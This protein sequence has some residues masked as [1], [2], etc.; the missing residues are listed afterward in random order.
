MEDVLG[1]YHRP[2]DEKHP[3]VC[4]DESSKQLIGEVTQ[5]IGMTTH[6]P[7]LQDD[8]YVRNG[9]AEI[10][11]AVEP[12]SGQRHVEITPTRTRIDWAQFVKTMLNQRYPDADKVVLVMDNLNT[13]SIGSL[14]EAFSPEEAERLAKRLEIHFTPKHGSWLNIA[15]I[16][17]AA[18][19]SGCLERRIENMETMKKEV[20]AWESYRNNKVCKVNWRFDVTDARVKLKRLYPI[21]EKT[22]DSN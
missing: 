15:E 17:L 5:P 2:Y 3:V 20:A 10:L 4:F 1:V 22:Q 21:F 16:E 7:R 19:K 9:V 8:E 13:H 14:Y 11:L 12:L 6:H 18:L